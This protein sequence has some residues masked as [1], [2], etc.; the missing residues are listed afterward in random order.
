MQAVCK[1]FVGDIVEE[2]RRVQE[3]WAHAGELLTE[4]EVAKGEIQE[5]DREA[6]SEDPKARRQ[7][8]LRP[9]HFAE[10]YRRWKGSNPGGGS[11]GSL[12]YWNQQ[13]RNGAERFA[14]KLNGRRLFR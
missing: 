2:A 14:P 5:E 7:P 9:E 11:G 6:L 10:A 8:P 1:L 4:E 3:E 12:M 13:T